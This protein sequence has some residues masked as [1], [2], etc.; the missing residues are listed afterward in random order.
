M[1]GEAASL[2]DQID[3]LQGNQGDI[4]DRRHAKALT[5]MKAEAEAQGTLNSAA[6]RNLVDLENTLHDLKLKNLQQRAAAANKVS[7]SSNTN[8]SASGN[9]SALAPP[10]INN[11]PT[12]EFTFAPNIFTLTGNA[13]AKDELA[14]A[15]FPLFQQL[16][17]NS[18]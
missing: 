11:R 16:V 13:A 7:S 17:A 9:G 8:S 2:Q 6:Y 3:Q 1:A 10:P 12:Q 14:R 18:R 5:D 15:L 4:E